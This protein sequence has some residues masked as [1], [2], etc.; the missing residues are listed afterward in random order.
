VKGASLL[1]RN[2]VVTV[3]LAGDPYRGR[4]DERYGS[5][6]LHVDSMV[7]AKLFQVPR[8]HNYD[9]SSYVTE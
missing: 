8:C 4:E 7:P 2:R 3:S 9:L 1:P 6:T 5:V